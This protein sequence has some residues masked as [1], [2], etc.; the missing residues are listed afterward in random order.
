MI[1]Y[2]MKY[3]PMFLSSPFR[4]SPHGMMVRI[5]KRTAAQFSGIEPPFWLFLLVLPALAGS[6]NLGSSRKSKEVG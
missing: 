4:L 3:Y 1:L 2:F 5:G 6:P